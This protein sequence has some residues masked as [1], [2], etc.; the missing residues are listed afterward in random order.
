LR[1]HA[2]QIGI[3]FAFVLTGL[4]PVALMVGL[5]LATGM[6]LVSGM[7]TYGYEAGKDIPEYIKKGEQAPALK[8]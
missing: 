1:Y 2:A 3:S 7:K 8:R 4:N 5:P 6:M